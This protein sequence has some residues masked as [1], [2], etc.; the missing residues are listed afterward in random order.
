MG[1]YAA[2]LCAGGLD[3]IRKEAWPFYRTSSGVR[4]CWSSKNRKDLKD[5]PASGRW[6]WVCLNAT[7]PVRHGLQEYLDNK[8]TPTALGPP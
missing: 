8:K 4:L 3:V 5:E 7:S 6:W 1:L 2:I